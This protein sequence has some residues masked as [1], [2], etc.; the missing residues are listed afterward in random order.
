MALDRRRWTSAGSDGSAAYVAKKG[1]T[2]AQ[3]RHNKGG[4][5]GKYGNDCKTKKGIGTYD[6]NKPV[7]GNCRKCGKKGHMAKDCRSVAGLDA[8]GSADASA[9]A[10]TQ[11]Q[12]PGSPAT[13]KVAGGIWVADG[14]GH[15]LVMMI[16]TEGVAAAFADQ[17]RSSSTSIRDRMCTRA[18]RSSDTQR[19]RGKTKDQ[20]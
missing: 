13:P 15:R 20:S 6:P 5:G 12:A 8:S 1:H 4:K 10:A 19:T 14:Q 9:S 3:R 16:G 17:M 11:P 2:E 18:H 7:T